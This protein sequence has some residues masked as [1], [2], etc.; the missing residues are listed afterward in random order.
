M[1]LSWD[2]IIKQGAN[3][4]AHGLQV[5]VDP[6]RDVIKEGFEFFHDSH[7]VLCFM[8]RRLPCIEDGSRYY[9]V[10]YKLSTVNRLRAA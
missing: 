1:S 6:G 3:V 2:S 10:L 5:D 7:V 9:I 8:K 4:N